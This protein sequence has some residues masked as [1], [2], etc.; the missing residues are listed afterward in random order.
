MT[1]W[2]FDAVNGSDSNPG[3]KEA[4]KQFYN[5]AISAAGDTFLFKRGVTQVVTTPYQWVQNGISSTARSRYGAYG[6]AQVPYSIWKYGASSGNMILS[7]AKTHWTDFE[8][9]YFDMRGTNCRNS[10]YIAAQAALAAYSI[11]IRRCFFQGSNLPLTRGGNGLN[12]SQESTATAYPNDIVVEDCEFFDNEGHGLFILGG[13]N[14]AV[15]RCKFYRNGLY[16]PTGGHGFSARYNYT[17]ASSGWTLTTGTI[18]QR[19]LAAVELDVYYIQT[20]VAAYPKV[21]RTAGS[22]TAPGAG[23]FGVSGGVLYINVNS[24]S[25]PSGQAIHYAWGRCCGLIVEDCESYENYWNR[26]APYHEGHG[27]AFDDFSDESVFRRNISYNNQG[28]GFSVNRGDRNQLIGNIAYGNWQAAVA[29]NPSDGTIIL[30]N[31]F[32][33]NN[34]GTGR[35]DAEIKFGGYCRDAVATNNILVSTVAYGIARETT[36]TG[37]SG[38][39]NAISG[40]TAAPEKNATVTATVFA[41]PKL[42]ERFYRPTA[43]E[44][45]R[46][47]IYVEHKD[48]NG[49]QFRNPPNI[50]AVDDRSPTSVRYAFV[51]TRKKSL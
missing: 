4:P 42:D 39:T 32:L 7:C 33:R 38:V 51:R 19:P 15:R 13:R 26:A 34:T 10:L 44:L 2:Y 37:F 28:A 27:F 25:N 17:N 23:E 20:S 30:N 16:E 41:P 50:G 11:G 12:I 36:D 3:T 49:K 18:W 8:D 48:F 1:I 9:M 45:I 22:Q 6:E 24:G 14:I 46:A 47:G 21:R 31:T 29:C 35:H 5:P 43:A 40:Y